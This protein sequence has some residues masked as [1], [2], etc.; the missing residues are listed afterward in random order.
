M[1]IPENENVA[2][3]EGLFRDGMHRT[4]RRGTMGTLE[5]LVWIL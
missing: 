3:D 4:R 5:R 2:D 1:C